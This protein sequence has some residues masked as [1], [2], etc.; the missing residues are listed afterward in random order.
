MRA[1][2]HV[3]GIAVDVVLP[4]VKCPP[5]KCFLLFYRY[6]VI[7]LLSTLHEQ[8]FAVDEVF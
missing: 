5:Q 1:F 3:A 4:M 7:V 8:V 6:E 2:Y